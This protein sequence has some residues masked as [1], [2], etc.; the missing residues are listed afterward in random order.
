MYENLKARGSGDRVSYVHCRKGMVS[1]RVF[2]LEQG[3]RMF[4]FGLEKSFIRTL[5]FK[6][7]NA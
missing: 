7:N 2:R 6:G 1:L 5:S 3:M 4:R